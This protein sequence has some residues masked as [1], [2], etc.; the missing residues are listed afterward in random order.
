MFQNAPCSLYDLSFFLLLYFV[1]PAFHIKVVLS[2]KL[3]TPDV[4]PLIMRIF[5]QKRFLRVLKFIK[6][7]SAMTRFPVVTFHLT[8]S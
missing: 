3:H 4:V 8:D 7:T 1:S 2:S 5:T 6:V